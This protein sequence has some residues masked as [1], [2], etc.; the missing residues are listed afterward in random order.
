[1]EQRSNDV[2]AMDVQIIKPKKEECALGTGQRRNVAATKDA[3]INLNVEECAGGMLHEYDASTAPIGAS[4]CSS[5][6]TTQR[7]MTHVQL[8]R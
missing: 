8:G 4:M 7:S 6:R 3:L 5:G 1:M 2:A